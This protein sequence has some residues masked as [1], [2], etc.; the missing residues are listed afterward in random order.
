M[1]ADSIR[2]GVSR[3]VDMGSRPWLWTICGPHPT[4]AGPPEHGAS[5]SGPPRCQKACRG[6]VRSIC[7]ID[8]DPSTGGCKS[9]KSPP[10]R[11]HTPTAHTR[12][13]RSPMIHGHRLGTTESGNV[14]KTSIDADIN[15]QVRAVD[16]DRQSLRRG[17]G[18]NPA[19][20]V[21]GDQMGP[22]LSACR[23]RQLCRR[24]A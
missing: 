4:P 9:F 20:K 24:Y 2:L 1:R 17:W 7:P 21:V 19:L 22:L 14:C 13:R 8:V 16:R 5:R 23:P 3:P 18:S 10:E 6:S 15:V 11:G 12:S